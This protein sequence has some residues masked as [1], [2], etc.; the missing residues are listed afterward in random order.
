[1]SADLFAEFNSLSDNPT[2]APTQQTTTP[3]LS[4]PQAQQQQQP[5][6]PKPL[7]RADTQNFFDLLGKANNASPVNG[8]SWSGFQ[9]HTQSQSQSTA[10]NAW[11]SAPVPSKPAETN[12]DDDDGWGDFEVAEPSQNPTVNAAPAQTPSPAPFSASGWGTGGS[13][14]PVS[15]NPSS[16]P[17]PKPNPGSAAAIAQRAP[18]I[19]QQ[20]PTRIVRASTMDLLSNSL[21]DIEALQKSTSSRSTPQPLSQPSNSQSH[22][23]PQSQFAQGWGQGTTNKEPQHQRMK[24][25]LKA[26]AQKDPSVLFDAEDFELQVAEDDEDE[27]EDED[28]FGD[29]E[30]VPPSTAPK[31][32]SAAAPGKPAPAPPSMDL[33]SLDEA[34]PAQP[35]P[36][37]QQ[38]R[39]APPTQLLGPLAFGATATNYPQAPKS[40]SFQDRN[41]FPELAIKTPTEPKEVKK[42]KEETPTTA[43]PSYESPVDRNRVEYKEQE[44]EWGDWDDFSAVDSK[45]ATASAR[46]APE[47]WDWDAADNVQPS[48]SDS[49]G[50]APPPINVPPPS[51][52]LSAFP[53]LMKSGTALF[54]PVSGQS[55]SIKQRILSDPKAV[56]FLQGYVLLA[57]TAA[58]VIAG[59][60]QRWHRD[61]ILAKSMSISAAGSKGMKLAGVDKTQAVREDREAADVV[62]V[63]RQQVG[64][65]RSAVAAAKSADKG[66]GLKVPEISENMQVHTARMVPTAPKACIIC[67]LKREERV[68]KVDVEVE[69]SFG[70]WWVDH[71]GHKA[72]KNF[73]IEHE[74]KLRQ[75]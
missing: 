30:S 53:D 34:A 74:Q 33:L 62:A 10:Q 68:A 75:R 19:K 47:S 36:Q 56:D 26:S 64:P 38:T 24:A 37:P 72:C 18:G 16:I 63:W 55:A 35:Q 5:Q 23:Q 43:W 44:E 7:Q 65:L 1:M 57:E 41:P 2:P 61:K 51:V 28:E 12:D 54:K 48:H 58:H 27:D 29:F 3:F 31:V 32:A 20:P 22:S 4:Q 8:Q 6:P 71:W 73:W 9:T 42:T 15:A 52:I 11:G 59:R 46:K 66:Q 17:W 40:P 60:K 21:V 69:D 50:D 39:K 45:K 14:T 70:E 67:G 49:Q 13:N 25:K